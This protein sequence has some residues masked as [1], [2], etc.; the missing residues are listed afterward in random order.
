MDASGAARQGQDAP[1][2]RGE[3]GRCGWFSATGLGLVVAGI[4]SRDTD[5]AEVREACPESVTVVGVQ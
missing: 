2:D 1:C 5:A 3:P 4:W